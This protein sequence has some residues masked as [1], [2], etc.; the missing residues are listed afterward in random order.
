MR[1][2]FIQPIPR[3]RDFIEK[4]WVF[5][6]DGALPNLDMRLFV[7]NGLVKL[8]VP[9]RNGLSGTMPGLSHVSKEHRM[10]L[11]GACDRPATID[12]Q[13]MGPSG[14]IGIEFRPSRAHRLFPGSQREI[15][16]GIYAL[17]DVSGPGLVRVEEAIAEAPSVDAK[18]A[19][20]QAF[21]ADRLRPGDDDPVFDFCVRA[22]RASRGVLPMAE[23]EDRTGYSAR[24]LRERFLQKLGLGPKRFAS[25]VRFEYSYALLMSRRAAKDIRRELYDLYYDESHFAKDF[26]RFTGLSPAR[27]KGRDNAFSGLFYERMPFFTSPDSSVPS[28]SYS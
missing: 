28:S 20:L 24:W 26:T 7:P 23:L 13:G 12:I 1:L 18:V 2:R 4:V 22:I 11:I 21:L 10:T 5:E 27:F 9:F 8:I 15:Q 3:L 16:N 6:S 17:D 19:L 14:S 25:V